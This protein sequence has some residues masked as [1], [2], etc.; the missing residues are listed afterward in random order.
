MTA[1][2][3]PSQ[4]MGESISPK[5]IHPRMVAKT[6]S[7]TEITAAMPAPTSRMPRLSSQKGRLVH[8][9]AS[10]STQNRLEA[11]MAMVPVSRA[12]TTNTSAATVQATNNVARMG[13]PSR[14]VARV[15]TST[16]A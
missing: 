8:S 13:V 3:P 7:E 9:T 6:T 1:N 5:N 2:R 16:P 15:T 12:R 14:R 10:P 4:P 11:L